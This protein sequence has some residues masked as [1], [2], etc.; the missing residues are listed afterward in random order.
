MK[1]ANKKA[2]LRDTESPVVSFEHLI[3][4]M[5]VRISLAPDFFNQDIQ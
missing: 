2:R 3:A 1:P 4:G 5:S